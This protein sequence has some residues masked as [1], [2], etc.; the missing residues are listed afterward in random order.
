M[1]WPATPR[2]HL[3]AASRALRVAAAAILLSI[4]TSSMATF[5][6]FKIH[7]L[8][9]NADGTV[10]FVVLREASQQNGEHLWADHA[11][12]AWAKG[13]VER[14]FTF[15]YPLPSSETSG[16][17][18]LVA[19]QAFADLRIV[20]PDYIMP[21]GFLTTTSGAV[22]FA[23]VDAIEYA[24]LPTDGETALFRDGKTGPNVA[25]NFGGASGSVKS[26]AAPPPPPPPATSI[27]VEYYYADWDYYFVTAFA[28]E[29]A[30]LDGGAFGG[31]WK[32]TGETF[33]VWP[34]SNASSSATCRFFSTSFSPKSSHFYT[35]FAAE[36][37]SVKTSR[38][39]QY[40]SIA[41][42]VAQAGADGTC[43]S[44]T[45]ALYRLYNNGKGGA[46][47]HRYTTSRGVFDTMTAAGWVFEGHGVTQVFACLPK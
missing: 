6:T 43:P 47:N 7:Q 39:W 8:F 37:E 22:D 20:K 16:K 15:E 10:Q 41:F 35:P 40:E 38:D 31:V 45:V 4:A 9:S 5:H 27:A 18:V 26:I 36:C 42:H 21:A 14:T 23:Q 46:P 19:T 24:S 13:G 30:V 28:D 33:K 3:R 12:A 17:Y 1:E 11:L 25:T 34:A 44:D 32:R 2:L 29:V